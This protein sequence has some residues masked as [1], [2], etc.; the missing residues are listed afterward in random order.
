MS[1]TLYQPTEADLTDSHNALF[2][3]YINKKYQLNIKTFEQC[4]QWSIAHKIDFWQSVVSYCGVHFK[5][6]GK[7]VISNKN[8]LLNSTWF[9]GYELNY[10]EHLLQNKSDEIALFFKSEDQIEKQISYK[11]LYQQV[12]KLQQHLLSLGIKKGDRVA[13]Y[14]PNMPQTIV[15][16]LAATTLGA[17]WSSCSPDFGVQGVVD[18]FGQI[19][20]VL[21]ITAD[22]YYYNG[23]QHDCIEKAEAIVSLI[24]SIKN[25]VVVEFDSSDIKPISMNVT[26][27]FHTYNALLDHFMAKQ[28][29]FA[30]LAFNHPLFI[31]YSSGTT[32]VPKCIVHGTGGTLIQHLKEHQLHSDFKSKEVVFYFTT[33]GWMMWNWLVSALASNCRLAIYDGSPF[34][35]QA[36]SLWQWAEAIQVA[37][38]GTSAKYIDA[39]NNEKQTINK[40][41][42]LRN[43]RSILSTGSPLLTASYDYVYQHIKQ[44]VRLVS[45]SGGT[46]ILSCFALGTPLKPIIK[47]QLQCAGLGMDVAILND[48]GKPVLE[49]K[50]EL[51]CLNSFPSKPIFFWNDEGNVRYKKA[52]FNKV[53]NVWCHGDF[54]EQTA[55]KGFIIYGR[56]DATLNPAG[57]RIGTAEIYRQVDMIDEIKESIVIGQTCQGDVRIVLFV[58]LNEGFELSNDLVKKIKQHIRKQTT[59][60]HVPAI[61][62]QVDDIPRTKSGKIVELAVT[63]VLAGETVKNLH[64]LANPEALQQF[65][66]RVELQ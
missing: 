7:Q 53:D 9:E 26:Q 30:S 46:D 4:H 13:A 22:S 54:A 29:Q 55:E 31:M 59:P 2:I 6:V 15:C 23:K 52:Y 25:L 36:D 28:C 42:S 10:A 34:Y 56:S 51:S 19:E 66:N 44:D 38:F 50:G 17:V 1:D 16:M 63:E 39:L 48:T 40:K 61:I 37:H 58:V 8:E 41:Y 57:V 62:L 18:R 49:E 43:L 27:E 12:S 65:K 32:G 21:F 20:P 5:H 60:R 24:P 45:I 14:M 64:A 35:P 47:G 11:T 3:K 33:C